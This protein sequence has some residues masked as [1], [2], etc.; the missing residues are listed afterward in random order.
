MSYP[1]LGELVQKVQGAHVGGLEVVL[2]RTGIPAAAAAVV[3]VLPVAV[4][5]AAAVV[6]DAHAAVVVVV[7]AAS[8]ALV[9]VAVGVACYEMSSETQSLICHHFLQATK[10]KSN[11]YSFRMVAVLLKVK[12]IN[13]LSHY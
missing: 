1:Q 8:V 4:A 5:A 2:V 3:A 13:Y 11:C 10:I 9:V 6:A 7:A 12:C